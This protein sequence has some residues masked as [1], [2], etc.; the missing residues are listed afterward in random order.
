MHLTE[1]GCEGIN[2]MSLSQ[3]RIQWRDLEKTIFGIWVL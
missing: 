3:D 1:I 2:W